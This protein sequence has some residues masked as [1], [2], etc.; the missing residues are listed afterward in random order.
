MSNR[1]SSLIPSDPL[2]PTQWYL[3]N[4]GQFPK[5]KP[6]EDIHVTSVWPDYTG[7]GITIAVVD[8]GFESSHPDLVA[9]YNFNAS[10]DLKTGTVGGLPGTNSDNHGTSVAGLISETANNGMG[11]VG[12]A[13]D[14][15]LIGYR[16]Q[17][18]QETLPY[19]SQY[20]ASSITQA[21]ASGAA[22]GSNSWGPMMDPFDVQHDQP[23][24]VAAAK[25]AVQL[26]RNG[27]GMVLLFASGNTGEFQLDAN[28]DPTDNLPYA[29]TVGAIDSAGAVTGFSTPGASVLVLGPGDELV[30]TDRQAM[31]GYTKLPGEAGNYTNDAPSHSYFDGTSGATPIVAGVV[32]LMLEANPLLGYRDVQDILVHSS[33]RADFIGNEGVFFNDRFMCANPCAWPIVRFNHIRWRICK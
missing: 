33:R 30:T 21:L 26:G 32:A 1:P 25:E 29:I 14:G 19:F 11:G 18:D 3:R 20:F 22:I 7:K 9:N 16:L 2:F 23:N 15:Q 6:G 31:L 24:Y 17:F 8:D 10:R 13:W 28:Y 5:A 12:V 4:T 27:L